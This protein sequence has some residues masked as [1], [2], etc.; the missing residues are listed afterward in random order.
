MG[1]SRGRR[2]QAAEDTSRQARQTEQQRADELRTNLT[3]RRDVIGAGLPQTMEST[4]R[5][6]EDIRETGGYRTSDIDLGGRGREGYEDFSKTGGFQEGEKEAFLRRASAPVTAMYARTK[7]ELDRRNALQGGYG[8]GYDTTS[9][10][11]LR[12]QAAAGSEATLAGNVELARQVREGKLAGLGGLERTRVQAGSE[13]AGVAAGRREGQDALQRYSQLGISALNDLD[14][15]DLRNRLQSGQ[16]SQ[17]DAQ[18]LAQLASQ[19]KTTFEKIMQGIS[20]V[21]GAAAG[22]LAA[23]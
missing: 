6:A 23:V 15:T 20:T 4:R 2:Q 19:D 3:Q 9:A 10:K 18:L 11:L 16:M 13:A 22:V 1:G 7:D 5:G 17:F 14:I 21:G 12:N 8:F